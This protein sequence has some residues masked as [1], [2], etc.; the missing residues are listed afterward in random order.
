MKRLSLTI[1]FSK[2]SSAN[3]CSAAK[4][5]RRNDL[6]ATACKHNMDS[7][8]LLLLC[9]FAQ[10]SITNSSACL[11]VEMIERV[12]LSQSSLSAWAITSFAEGGTYLRSLSVPK[13][14]RYN[15]ERNTRD[16]LMN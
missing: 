2:L 15:P 16:V 6:V 9:Q 8:K 7:L 12:L 10:S 3:T 14:Q 13:P 1:A 5:L 4:P 11:E